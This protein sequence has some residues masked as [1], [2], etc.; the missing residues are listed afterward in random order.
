MK[1]ALFISA[2]ICLAIFSQA[3]VKQKN[4]LSGK[5]TDAKTG[6]PLSGASILL[7]DTKQGTVSG[8]DGSYLFNNIPSGHALIEVSF[9]GYRSVVEQI[10][11]T[12]TSRKD[13]ALTVSI[14][15]N[16]AVTVTGVGAATS[17]RRAPIPITRVSKEDLLSTPSTNIIDAL[18]KQPG[19]NQLSTGPAISKPVIRGLGY[20]RL[21]VINDG[22]RQEGQQ[23]GDEHGIE[24]DENSVSRIEVVKGPASLIYGSDALAGVINIITTQPAPSQTIQGSVLGSYATNNKQRTL[25]ANLGG[26][27]HGFNWNLWGDYKAASDYRNRYDGLVWN[28]KFNEKNLGGYLGYNGAWGYSHLVVS[29]FNQRLG[30]I[31]GERNA[32]GDFVRTLPGGIQAEPAAADFNSTEPSVPYQHILHT[33]IILDNSLRLGTGRLS[34]TFAGQRNE[35]QEFGN[36]D[37]PSERGL[38]FDLRT[39][40]YSAAYHTGLHRGWNTTW[41]LNGMAQGNRNKGAEALI[42]EY[43]LFDIGAFVYSQKTIGKTTMSGGLRFDNRH[44]SSKEFTEAGTQKF[45]AFTKDYSNV[46]ASLGVSYAATKYLVFKANVARGFRAPSIPELSSNGAHEGTNRY[47]YGEQ[48]LVSETSWQGDIGFEV[49]SEHAFFSM[50]AF[51]NHIGNFIFYSKLQAAGGA[52]STVLVGADLIPAF[53]FGQ[54]TANLAGLEATLDLHPHPLDWL[55]WENNFSYV[56]G[57]FSEAIDGSD[58]VPFIPSARWISELRAELLEKGKWVRA[59]NLSLEADHSFAQNQPFTGFETETAT[60]AYTL[61]NAGIT[62]KITNGKRPLL[63]IYL[64]ASNITDVA[65]QPHMSRLKY[66]DVNVATGRPGV[67]NMGRSYTIRV[68]IP[69]SFP[70]KEKK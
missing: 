24:I 63:S 1:Y 36:P 66:T 9:Q 58:D 4:T 53:K 23:W 3:Q 32:A 25:F 21:V 38:Y 59:L 37:D 18:R 19:V 61:I 22:V 65:Y 43:D 15:E 39:F 68:N 64:L 20:N 29:R 34:L 56:R 67:F 2:F 12:G 8:A 6:G 42:P 17:V 28:S 62:A 52:D 35:R 48:N 27:S 70:I 5:I 10:D 13:F 69:F 49:N 60:P 45:S 40:N 41:G 7:V 55:H 57:R 54:H 46:S 11:L 31:E 16:E 44:L 47:E 30:L 14:I 33:K 50:S 26:N 51:Y